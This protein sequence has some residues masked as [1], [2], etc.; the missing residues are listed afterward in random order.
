M[1]SLLFLSLLLP[2]QHLDSVPEAQRTSTFCWH[3]FDGD[4]GQD[5]L[6]VQPGGSLRL[7]RHDGTGT[8]VDETGSMGLLDFTGVRGVLVGDYDLDGQVDLVLCRNEGLSVLYREGDIFVEVT[9]GVG[10]AGLGSVESVRWVDVEGDG[11]PDLHL[12]CPREHRVFVNERGAAFRELD[13][14]L[15]TV[16]GPPMRWAGAVTGDEVEAPQLPTGGAEGSTSAPGPGGRIPLAGGSGTSSLSAGSVGSVSV[17]PP[18]PIVPSCIG[19]VEDQATGFCLP[20]SSIPTLGTLYPLGNELMIDSAAG[21]VGI[22]TTTPDYSLEVAGQLISGT[23]N[24]ASGERSTVSGGARNEALE[25]ETTIGGGVDNLIEDSTLIT[26]AAK[27]STISGGIDNS[28]SPET[29]PGV[30]E[31]DT[32][33]STIG[34]GESNSIVGHSTSTISGGSNNSIDSNY[35]G[36][37][38]ATIAGGGDNSIYRSS[39]AT[40]GGGRFNGIG[41]AS[42]ATIGGGRYN[43]VDE[44][45]GTIPGGYE[46]SVQGKFSFAAGYR[47]KAL[48][49]G[50]F[51]WADNS[52][53]ADFE[54]TLDHQFLVRARGGVG[55]NTNATS[56]TALSIEAAAA[57]TAVR[58]LNDNVGGFGLFVRAQDSSS[59]ENYGVFTQV[60]SPNGYALYAQAASTTGYAGYFDGRVGTDEY[61]LCFNPNNPGASVRLGWLN[62]VARIRVGGNGTGAHGGLD[63][64]TTGDTSL[65]RILDNGRVGIGDTTPSEKLDVAGD[66]RCVQV[67]E[68]SDARLKEDVLELEGALEAVLAMRGVSFEWD[69]EALP[70]AHEGRKLGLLAQELREVLPE[71]VR[72]GEDGYLSVS[73]SA[74]VPV[75]IEGMQEQQR[76]IEELRDRLDRLEE[77]L[78][79]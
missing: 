63:I 22:G 32:S 75:L 2:A 6:V 51:V 45:Y 70:A 12:A 44:E 54:T 37:S 78:H 3:D 29:L 27:W 53:F 61:F 73:Y 15:P 19:G 4:G 56:T 55:I 25:L 76:E 9:D 31:V 8:L 72:E 71:A 13:L 5:A 69:R 64:Q 59:S 1:H 35:L 20:A 74:V 42:D 43:Q 68:T 46:N 34:G 14:G 18:A 30:L 60:D 33:G 26:N 38:G 50:C 49:E 79:R 11:V 28:I 52:E 17:P 48:N 77:R 10:L 67:I 39:S 65:V 21:Y 47:A 41:S 66:V 57:N 36:V 24:S 7:L 62:D 58:V 16:V 40:I 23:S